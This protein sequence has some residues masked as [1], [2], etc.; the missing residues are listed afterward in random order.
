GGRGQPRA[1]AEADDAGMFEETADDALDA[2]VVGEAG[3]A[4]PQTADTAH[5][6][7]DLDAGL[8]GAV[9]RVDQLLI[10]DLVELDPDVAGPPRLHMR[11]LLVDQAQ[12]RLPQRQRRDGD[13]LELVRIRIARH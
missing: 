9:E 8:R 10:H 3:Y 7:V 1:G 2:D 5:D 4:R 11:D 13:L 6:E 12:Q